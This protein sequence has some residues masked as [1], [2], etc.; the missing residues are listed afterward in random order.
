MFRNLK[1]FIGHY[2]TQ[3]ESSSTSQYRLLYL[4][5]LAKHHS[6]NRWRCRMETLI[7][8]IVC[9]Y[10]TMPP[11][12][13]MKLSKKRNST[14]HFKNRWGMPRYRSWCSS[15]PIVSQTLPAT[16]GDESIESFKKMD[17]EIAR[18]LWDNHLPSFFPETYGHGCPF[19]D[20]N[21]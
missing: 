15:N 3:L 9:Y 16:G 8:P 2:A 5:M 11:G 21:C 17:F 12:L 13:I 4:S 7:W 20:R 1:H 18:H 19:H 6:T 14:V 10:S